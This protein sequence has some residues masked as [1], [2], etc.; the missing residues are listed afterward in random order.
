MPE[1][2]PPEKDAHQPVFP[3]EGSHAQMTSMAGNYSYS[4]FR[5][6]QE[7]AATELKSEQIPNILIQKANTSLKRDQGAAFG[8]V[9]KML[10][11]HTGVLGFSSWLQLPILVCR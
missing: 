8:P 7:G 9:V 3:M 10:T 6:H 1:L 11:S 4:R 2:L 5:D